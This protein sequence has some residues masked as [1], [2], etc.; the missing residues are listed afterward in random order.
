MAESRL[1][2][3]SLVLAKATR[4]TGLERVSRRYFESKEADALLSLSWAVAAGYG[5]MDLASVWLEQN[6]CPA[7]N[8]SVSSA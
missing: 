8:E 6:D 2:G 7:H 5:Q 3:Q 4:D 1:I